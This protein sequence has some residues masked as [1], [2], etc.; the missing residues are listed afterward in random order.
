MEKR[1][2]GCVLDK[3]SEDISRAVTFSGNE[4][5]TSGKTAV[6]WQ[7][8]SYLMS[9]ASTVN[10]DEWQQCRLILVLTL[11][12]RFRLHRCHTAAYCYYNPPPYAV[13]FHDSYTCG[14]SLNHSFNTMNQKH[15]SSSCRACCNVP[16]TYRFLIAPLVN[17]F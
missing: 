9:D 10:K 5:D 2:A 1:R 11:F 7:Y 12:H 13:N 15:A 3:N 16:D 17:R 8:F 6:L 14:I 4:E